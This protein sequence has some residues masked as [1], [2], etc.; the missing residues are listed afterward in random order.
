MFILLS[1]LS[2]ISSAV[3]WPEFII[4]FW[5]DS[6]CGHSKF[7]G[8]SSHSIKDTE[9]A[10]KK[11]ETKYKFLIVVY[12]KIKSNTKVPIINI[13]TNS[14]FVKPNRTPEII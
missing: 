1:F 10:M 8:L 7:L 14:L 12:F 2:G 3:S 4:W 11:I 9:N 6:C 5:F 13:R